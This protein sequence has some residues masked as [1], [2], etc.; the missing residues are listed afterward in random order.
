M[1]NLTHVTA[2]MLA[3]ALAFA[4]NAQAPS[5]PIVPIPIPISVTTQPIS[6]PNPSP[7]PIETI[8]Q[9]PLTS[10]ADP[11]V[12]PGPVMPRIRDITRLHNSMPHLLVGVGIVTSLQG[13][14]SSDRGTRQALL[15][16]IR[17]QNLNYTIA[18][19]T[20]GNIALV[21]LT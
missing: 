4:A 11:V 7:L 14:G 15:N 20:G 16:L 2:S 3:L 8:S 13:T 5:L 12:Q 21:S 9:P 6:Q 19:V 10:D 1:R 17:D 18:D